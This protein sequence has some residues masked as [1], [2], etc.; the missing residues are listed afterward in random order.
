MA[1]SK[2]TI[3]EGLTWL[4]TLEARRTELVA[5]RNNN[6]NVQRNFY[7]SEREARTEIVP[8][9]DVVALDQQVNL[10]SR[11]IRLCDTAIKKANATTVLDQYLADDDV[12][13]ELSKA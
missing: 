5:L 7:G 4:K 10:L 3:S 13:G 12:L 11:E 9:Y 1:K 6:A 8:R 2:I